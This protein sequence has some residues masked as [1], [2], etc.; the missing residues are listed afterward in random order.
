VGT[1][2][3]VGVALETVGVVPEVTEAAEE[4]TGV[5]P[6]GAGGVADIMFV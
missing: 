6:E 5:V 1:G 2:V 4:P 3:A